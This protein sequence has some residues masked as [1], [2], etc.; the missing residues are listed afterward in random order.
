MVMKKEEPAAEQTPDVKPDA[1]VDDLK[2]NKDTVSDLNQEDLD[3][4]DGGLLRADTLLGCN[5]TVLYGT[6]VVITCIGC[7]IVNK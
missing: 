2:L 3:K 1:N 7:P 4:V 6:C 5:K